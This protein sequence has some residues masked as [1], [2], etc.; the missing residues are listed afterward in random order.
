MTPLLL[1]K[2]MTKP[3]K[4]FP[5]TSFRASVGFALNGLRYVFQAERNFRTHLFLAA[6]AFTSALLCG[7]ERWEWV[8]LI[9]CMGLMTVVEVLN[10][11]IELLVDHLFGDKR[12][13]VAGR[14]KDVSAGACLLTALTVGVVGAFLFIPH[15]YAVSQA[16]LQTGTVGQITEPISMLNEILILPL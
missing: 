7:F 1:D 2:A 8:A 6:L 4:P 16:T 5:A 10:T 15:F 12:N 14:I 11:A 3:D 13:V 9:L